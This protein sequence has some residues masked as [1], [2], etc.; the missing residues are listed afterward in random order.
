M[1]FLSFLIPLLSGH[2]AA[3]RHYFCFLA[4]LR[5][6]SVDTADAVVLAVVVAAAHH[7]FCYMFDFLNA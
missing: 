3:A 1:L 7:Y 6:Q 2:V 4:M 5:F